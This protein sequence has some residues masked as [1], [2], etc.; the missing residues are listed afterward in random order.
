VDGDGRR[1]RVADGDLVS[2]FKLNR[3]PADFSNAEFGPLEVGE[4]RDGSDV[5]GEFSDPL[6]P[7]LLRFPIAMAAVQPGDVHPGVDQR[8][9][10]LFRVHRRSER[11][12]HLG[13]SFHGLM[14]GRLKSSYGVLMQSHQPQLELESLGGP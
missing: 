14:E 8:G 12:N 6:D 13:A 10:L 7:L 4:D 1:N 3:A 5:W 2:N 9:D 11:A